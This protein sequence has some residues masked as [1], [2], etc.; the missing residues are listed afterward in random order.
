MERTFACPR[1]PASLISNARRHRSG[2]P[3]P[4]DP[5]WS[6][7]W[8]TGWAAGSCTSA[9][10][11]YPLTVYGINESTPGPAWKALF[12]V[13][14]PAYRAWYLADTASS[15]PDLA[16]AM[17]MLARHMPE[18]LPTYRH[19]VA[20]AGNDEVAA[21]MLTLWDAPPFLPACSQAVLTAPEPVLCRNYD[22]SPELWERTVYCSAFTGRKVIGTG[23]CLWG[24]LDGMNDAGLVISLTYGGR[25]GSGTGFAIPLVVR[26]LLEVADTTAQAR[27]L[28][29]G[30]P[31]AMSYN[32]TMVDASGDAGTAFVAP[33]QESEFTVAAVA[34]NHHGST[35]ECPERAARFASVQRLERLSA[36]VAEELGPEALAAAFQTAPLYN[37]EY[38]RAFGTLYT[39]VYRPAEQVVEYHWPTGVWRRGFD[40]PG[41]TRQ[42]VLT[43][44]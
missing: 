7:R 23:D 35:P 19:L 42:I 29:R 21:R 27:E 3:S 33:G 17:A 30:L 11:T 12:D 24:L 1:V 39:A 28:L 15:R 20:L 2:A 16:T 37:D 4:T 22:Y 32:L 18:L 8:E 41:D 26:Y 34:T 9:A 5:R 6:A 44:R 31:I 36:L 40:D 13:T 10:R 43:G 38:D 25:P 14:W